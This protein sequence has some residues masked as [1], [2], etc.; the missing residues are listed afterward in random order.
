MPVILEATRLS[1]GG[2]ETHSG[3][4]CASCTCWV[5]LPYSYDYWLFLGF[6]LVELYFLLPASFTC[7]MDMFTCLMDLM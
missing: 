6:T 7:L 1:V 3:M 2:G 4:F 5:M